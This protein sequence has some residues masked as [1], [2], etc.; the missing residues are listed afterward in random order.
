MQ[1]IKPPTELS[2]GF[3]LYQILIF[4]LTTFFDGRANN[5]FLFIRAT[6]TANDQVVTQNCGCC[7]SKILSV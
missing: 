5:L 7:L 2:R 1:E 3:Y 4:V 6:I